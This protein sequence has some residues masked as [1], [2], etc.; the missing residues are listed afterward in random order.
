MCGCGG[1]SN[2]GKTGAQ[3]EIETD[4]LN[5]YDDPTNTVYQDR[6]RVRLAD[7]EVYDFE[8]SS[9]CSGTKRYRATR[10]GDNVKVERR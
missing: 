6:A 7:G 4:L 1:G 2:A 3:R 9:F 8:R 5:V 10:T